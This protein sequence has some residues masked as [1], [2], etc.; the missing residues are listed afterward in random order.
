M[1]YFLKDIIDQE[2]YNI[3]DNIIRL[4]KCDINKLVELFYF[5][6]TDEG[7]LLFCSNKN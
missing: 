1:T 5:L 3:D 4:K 6:G 2:N 7:L